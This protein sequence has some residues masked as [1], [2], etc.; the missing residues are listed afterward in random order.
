MWRAAWTRGAAG[1]GGAGGILLPGEHEDLPSCRNTIQPYLA[2]W[3][4]ASAASTMPRPAPTSL[5]LSPRPALPPV[6]CRWWRFAGS[7]R[8]AGCAAAAESHRRPPGS[9]VRPHHQH[10]WLGGRDRVRAPKVH[11]PGVPGAYCRTVR[12]AVRT[13]VSP[14]QGVGDQDAITQRPGAVYWALNGGQALPNRELRGA[15][16]TAG[17]HR[18]EA[19]G[20]RRMLSVAT[21]IPNPVWPPPRLLPYP[22]PRPSFPPLPPPLRSAMWFW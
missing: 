8:Q 15:P 22:P 9:S 14:Y 13:G 18:D 5:S 1:G 12:R 11:H 6:R 7:D 16:A 10:L 3:P 17:L 19:E 4:M 20:A 2:A 21:D